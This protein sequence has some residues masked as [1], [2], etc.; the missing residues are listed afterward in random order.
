VILQIKWSKLYRTNYIDQGLALKR[1]S[2]EVPDGYRPHPPPCHHHDHFRV[3]RGHWRRNLLLLSG[4]TPTGATPVWE[5]SKPMN[6]SSWAPI[7]PKIINII[8]LW[9]QTLYFRVLSSS[10]LSF[11]FVLIL[12]RHCPTISPASTLST[13]SQWTGELPWGGMKKED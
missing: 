11:P 12:R 4:N 8:S 5:E 10:Y 3:L 6:V 7:K 9:A 13:S 2:M 1:T